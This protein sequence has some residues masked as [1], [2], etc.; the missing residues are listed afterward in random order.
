MSKEIILP[1]ELVDFGGTNGELNDHCGIITEMVTIDEKQFNEFGNES[2]T[3][4]Q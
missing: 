2:K 3:I 4:K 1:R